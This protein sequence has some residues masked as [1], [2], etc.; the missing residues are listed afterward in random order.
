MSYQNRTDIDKYK[1]L[2]ADYLLKYHNIRSLRKPF[3]CLNPNHN[4]NHPSMNYSG[5]YN[6]C[7]CFAC[8]AT[9]D[10]FGLIGIDYNIDSFPEQIEI[11]KSLYP[12]INTDYQ[13]EFYV[14]ERNDNNYKTI[15]FT[16][17][18]QKCK[19]NI[20]KTNYLENRKIDKSLL[21]KYNVGYDENKE[22]IVFPI[23]K[24]SYFARGV[25]SDLKLK[26][27][28]TSYL[29]NEELLKDS[30]NNII[31]VTESIIDSLS[32]ETIN[33]N[34]KTVALNGVSNYK[35]LIK[36]VKEFDYKGLLVLA[37]DKDK[38]GLYYQTI[39][40]KE[41]ADINVDSFSCSLIENFDDNCKDLNNALMENREKLEK[42]FEYINLNLEKYIEK[43]QE[44]RKEELEL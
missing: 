26:S 42:N 44:K 41:L 19:K 23:N 28:G 39:V 20:F 8:G 35:R 6:I 24:N 11:A 29:W 43:K 9:Y 17:Y 1:P 7:K 31:Y 32:L 27:K 22:M 4:D 3:N 12:N 15:D 21:E 38:I 18:Y 34:V 33:K 36:I 13:K 16:N 40:D 25:N 37:F 2:L 10:L 14:I 5:R 30:D